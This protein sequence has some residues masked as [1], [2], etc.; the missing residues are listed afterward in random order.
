MNGNIR[1][2]RMAD[3]ARL[4][5]IYKATLDPTS[6]KVQAGHGYMGIYTDQDGNVHAMKWMTHR[7]E[8]GFNNKWNMWRMKSAQGDAAYLAS[9]MLANELRSLARTIRPDAVDEVDRILRNYTENTGNQSGGRSLLSRRVVYDA[10]RAI[11]NNI[12]ITEAEKTDVYLDKDDTRVNSMT[13][14]DLAGITVSNLNVSAKVRQFLEGSEQDVDQQL[15]AELE[16]HDPGGEALRAVAKDV[17]ACFAR[18]DRARQSLSSAGDDYQTVCTLLYSHNVLGTDLV[19]AQQEQLASVLIAVLRGDRSANNHR[20]YFSQLDFEVETC[21]I[22]YDVRGAKCGYGALVS[23]VRCGDV[24]KGE[25]PAI[26][27]Q[28]MGPDQELDTS[29]MVAEQIEFDAAVGVREDVFTIPGRLID[30]GGTDWKLTLGDL[31]RMVRDGLLSSYGVVS[32]ALHVMRQRGL[33]VSGEDVNFL[34]DW[35]ESRTRKSV[36]D[37]RARVF[38]EFPEGA[39]PVFD[40]IRALYGNQEKIEPL[41]WYDDVRFAGFSIWDVMTEFAEGSNGL[42]N[43][44]AV[45]TRI[46]YSPDLPSVQDLFDL[47]EGLGGGVG[48]INQAMARLDRYETNEDQTLNRYRLALMEILERAKL[49][50]VQKQALE[51]SFEANA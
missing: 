50:R 6:N 33:P 15:L 19:P 11:K 27:R 24:P 12:T 3:E 28:S 20:G 22:G 14:D 32:V 44:N 43:P 18:K 25:L 47:L 16:A 37:T 10:V 9:E 35:A 31:S 13:P 49:L 46:M 17:I 36:A 40:F 4:K 30:G 7:T 45:L 1:N 26:V 38:D 48:D 29:R 51:D 21:V 41:S 23:A 8:R 34:R 42:T 2:A 39:S 5:E